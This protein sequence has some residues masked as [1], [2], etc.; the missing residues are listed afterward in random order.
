MQILLDNSNYDIFLLQNQQVGDFLQ[1]NLW[2]DFLNQQNKKNWQ[3]VVKDENDAIAFCLLYQNDLPL[4]R[5]F[6]YTPKGPVF[7]KNI[8]QEKKEEALKLILSKV[9][10]L[11]IG[12]KKREEI[13][14]KIEPN[15]KLG[16][17]AELKK[18]D[19]VQ[20]RDTWLLDLTKSSD[21]LLAQMHP[22]TRYN[23]NLASKHKIAI[24]FSN[25]KEDL[26]HFLLL[27]KKTAS[28]NQIS[29]HGDEYYK[30]LWDALIKHRCGEL[31]LAKKDQQIIAAN[32]I[33]NFG[34]RSTYLHGASDYNF[35]SLMAPQLLQWQSILRAKNNQQT[36]YDFWGVAPADN[37]KPKWEGF[38]R[39][40]KS[41][42][43]QLIT[44]PGAYNL[45][46]DEAW[47]RA[48]NFLRKIKALF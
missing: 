39:F 31:A 8:S 13:F 37:S 20:P 3:L 32:I 48:Y 12:T 34:Q 27:I 41:F 30:K 28:R 4:G 36:I 15:E 38:S 6:L 14:F 25:K 10:D 45:I 46:Y 26:E 9:R 1:S 7:K 19:D 23:I 16:T 5:S 2:R 11:T 33:V 40:K 43:G 21:E 44:S 35:R 18:A 29:V 42:G 22:K 24:E 47:F 17:L